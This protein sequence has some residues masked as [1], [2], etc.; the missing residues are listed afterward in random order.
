RL[1]KLLAVLVGAV[2]DQRPRHRL[3][4]FG[5]HLRR[6]GSEEDALHRGSSALGDR[7]GVL[8][9]NGLLILGNAPTGLRNAQ[10]ASGTCS[11][12]GSAGG[13]S[14][15]TVRTATPALA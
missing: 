11:S 1:E 7:D 15:S 3:Q 6:A 8:R 12:P 5:G 4:D 9:K 13:A 2:V 14:A 10:C